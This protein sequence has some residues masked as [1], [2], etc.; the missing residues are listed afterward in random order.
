MARPRWYAGSMY[1]GEK[2]IDLN[3]CQGRVVPRDY[4]RGYAWSVHPGYRTEPGKTGHTRT[5]AAAKLAARRS[6]KRLGPD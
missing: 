3:N 2:L 4:G 5:E 1:A 6:C